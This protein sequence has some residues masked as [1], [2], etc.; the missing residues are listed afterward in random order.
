[1]PYSEKEISEFWK[2][3]FTTGEY[4]GAK[5]QRRILGMLPSSPRCKICYAPFEGIGAPI[6]RLVYRRRRSTMNPRICSACEDMVRE[7][8]SGAE[9]PMSML[10]ADVRGSTA[11]SERMS[12]MEF[13]RLINRFYTEVTRAIVETDGLV[14]KLAGDSVAAFWGEGIAGHDYVARTIE[15]ALNLLKATGHADPGGPWIPVGVGVHAGVAY[16]GAMGGRWR[17][18]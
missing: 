14:D 15:A 8:T 7:S 17:P 9:V 5:R 10:F 1:M 13:S 6:A 3:W 11:L 2:S 4:P 16:F 12:P 18:V